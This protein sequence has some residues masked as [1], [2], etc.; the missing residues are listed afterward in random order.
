MTKKKTI[1]DV[2]D[3]Y[4]FLRYQPDGWKDCD[5]FDN[6]NCL[7]QSTFNK[8]SKFKPNELIIKKY[9]QFIN[10][11]N[12]FTM[13][14]FNN[15][16]FKWNNVVIAGGSISKLLNSKTFVSDI[17]ASSD[18]DL[19]IYGNTPHERLISIKYIIEFFSSK[20]TN[21]VYFV[22]RG[23]VVNIFIANIKRYFQIV[24]TNFISI[25]E[26][27]YSFDL[28]NVRVA[29][30][31][32]KI[33]ACPSF[34]AALKFQCAQLNSSKFSFD[35]IIKLSECGYSLLYDKDM[36][37]EIQYF[38]SRKQ[39]IYFPNSDE[40]TEDIIRNLGFSNN[41]NIKF[42][43]QKVDKCLSMISVDNSKNFKK[44]K[45]EQTDSSVILNLDMI[46]HTTNNITFTGNN[47]I[48]YVSV[49]KRNN[50]CFEIPDV[51]ILFPIYSLVQSIGF[52]IDNTNIPQNVI[53]YLNIILKKYL[54]VELFN[55][56]TVFIDTC[57]IVINPKITKVFNNY[58]KIDKDDIVS[59]LI[60]K[61]VRVVYCRLLRTV[62]VSNK[63]YSLKLMCTEIH[64]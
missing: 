7:I 36:S 16:D 14:L 33:M 29:Y 17:P 3:Y 30:L 51:K 41:V 50:P 49:F 34:I 8:T 1:I 54:S 12:A 40:I 39:P 23:N 64:I 55:N 20:F 62:I 60:H 4:D 22:V 5:L 56:H 45:S 48:M 35:R 28:D 47:K 57:S 24:I 53:N 58:E 19:F 26:I 37:T 63:I 6:N 11:F 43:T 32:G 46:D 52:Q 21:K 27:I 61:R 25:D 44:Y 31:N 59:S 15:N 9:D 38:Y 10:D 18:I 42:I 2:Y 13:E